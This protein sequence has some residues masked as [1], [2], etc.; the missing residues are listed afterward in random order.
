[1]PRNVPDLSRPPPPVSDVPPAPWAPYKSGP[2]SYVRGRAMAAFVQLPPA[3]SADELEGGEPDHPHQ[4]LADRLS[5]YQHV[6]GNLLEDAQDARRPHPLVPEAWE[7]Q[8]RNGGED[9]SEESSEAAQVE[10]LSLIHI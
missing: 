9:T 2:S 5:D 4:D 8:E 3:F 1:M 10:D 7:N 6:G